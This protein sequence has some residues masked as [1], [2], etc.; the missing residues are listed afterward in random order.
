MKKINKNQEPNTLTQF[1]RR[2]PTAVY[3][4]L[5]ADS[6]QH[7]R[8]DIRQACTTEQFYLCAYCCKQIS[9]GNKDTMNEHL[10]PQ[11]LAP[12]FSLDFNNIIASCTTKGQCDSAHK[13]QR[14]PLTPLM[15]EC[16]TEFVFKLS[17]RV[18]GLTERARESISVLNLGD[19]ENNNRALIEKRKQLVSALLFNNGI[20]PA[21]PVEDDDV[22]KMVID[23]LSQPVNGKLQAYAPVVVNILRDWITK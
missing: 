15:K 1:K 7:I 19:N 22:L 9:G 8:Q 12:N 14:L 10:I 6:Q 5:T 4:D 13:N 16:E 23:D 11:D 21:D 2:H 18:E 17:G 20:N 3:A